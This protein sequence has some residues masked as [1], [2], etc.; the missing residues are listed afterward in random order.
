MILRNCPPEVVAPRWLIRVSLCFVLY[1]VN[2]FGFI[3]LIRPPPVLYF[4][5]YLAYNNIS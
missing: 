4:V 3:L 1:S 2:L 5:I